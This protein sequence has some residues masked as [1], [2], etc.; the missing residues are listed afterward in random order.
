[1]FTK[2]D[3]EAIDELIRSR[4]ISASYPGKK[5]TFRPLSEL[6]IVRAFIMANMVEK[7][8]IPMPPDVTGYGM[9]HLLRFNPDPEAT[10]NLEKIEYLGKV[11][12]VTGS[13]GVI[14]SGNPTGDATLVLKKLD[15][16]GTIYSI[17]EDT[18]DTIEAG[19]GITITGTTTKSI[20]VTNPFTDADETKLDSIASGAEVNVKSDWNAT[21]GDAE[22][23]NKP[24]ELTA[25]TGITISNDRINIDNPFTEADETKLD[26]IEAGA[27]V[28]VQSDW[29]ATAGDA[30]IK[31]KP[32][33]LTAGTGI[34]ITSNAINVANPYS[35]AEKTKLSGIAAGAEVN[36]KSDWTATSGDA[37]IL[38]KPSVK[39]NLFHGW[40]IP[41]GGGANDKDPN[42]ATYVWLDENRARFAVNVTNPD[43]S[44][45]KY[46][47]LSVTDS[48][49]NFVENGTNRNNDL[50]YM[51]KG[52]TFSFFRYSGN[53]FAENK[54]AEA[55]WYGFIIGTPTYHTGAN[56]AYW[57]VPVA[58]VKQVGAV[59]NDENFYF[60]IEPQPYIIDPSYI[61]R[62]IPMK[63][64]D[65]LSTKGKATTPLSS[66]TPFYTSDSQGFIKSFTLDDLDHAVKPFALSQ[67]SLSGYKYYR[68]NSTHV[69]RNKKGAILHLNIGQLQIVPKDGD[70]ETLD[71]TA[72]TPGHVIKIAASDTVYQEYYVQST[73]TANGRKYFNF[74]AT[75]GYELVGTE[76]ADD[77]TVSIAGS[78][79]HVPFS[80]VVQ[81][82]TDSHFEI[83]STHAL[84]GRVLPTGGTANQVATKTST[85]VAW[86]DAS[87][88]AGHTLAGSATNVGTSWT[89]I[90]SSAL[91]DDDL[92]VVTITATVTNDKVIRSITQRFADI[93]SGGTWVSLKGAASGAR[94]DIRR[95]STNFEARRA[96]PVT[97]ANI[98]VRVF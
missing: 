35:T 41:N 32:A 88:Y 13:G 34:T 45:L 6:I 29:N 22:I 93:D 18:G 14:V 85:G 83:P 48:N 79:P 1:M 31:N 56:G 7:G 58:H 11:F 4:A 78:S 74:S 61:V 51:M 30:L 57:E 27:E 50:R 91:G 44:Q 12:G 71:E 90:N 39:T 86:Q 94:L 52:G 80:N 9:E 73:G 97:N 66:T 5:V 16:D 46:V 84:S 38:E 26:G 62:P 47:R 8:I 28:N 10:E 82:L 17:P 23:L 95:N 81:T 43:M 75:E 64:L 42:D 69:D 65:G 55:F 3:L 89:A 98:W 19:D 92:L 21:S 60:R 40:W 67:V 72:F 2:S 70:I 76:P 77:A 49:P 54:V 25:G 68:L 20:A 96:G 63:Q 87:S 53:V 59:E 33:K 37:Q 36:V 24:A 15:I